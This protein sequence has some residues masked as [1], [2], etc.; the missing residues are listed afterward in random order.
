MVLKARPAMKPEYT[1]TAQPFGKRKTTPQGLSAVD[2][3]RKTTSPLPTTVAAPGPA[4]IP[5]NA[6][7][8][9]SSIDAR[10]AS[11]LSVTPT[12]ANAAERADLVTFFGPD[13]DKYLQVYEK[14]IAK[15]DS[16]SFNWPVFGLSFVW[17][18]YRK[19]YLMGAV[20][21]IL[22]IVMGYVLPFGAQM[23]GAVFA[24]FADR[25]YLWEAKRH[26]REASDLGLTGDER[27]DYLRRAGG[28]SLRAGILAG[29]FYA[30]MGALAFLR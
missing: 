2:V 24:W 7:A 14:L 16:L 6:L 28:V 26:I 19:M 23:S 9:S 4:P 15:P 5:G 27:S 11:A 18:F 25:A 1:M 20:F 22:P 30:G 8:Q 10:H 12:T 13:S 3:V 17:F 29:L 21:V